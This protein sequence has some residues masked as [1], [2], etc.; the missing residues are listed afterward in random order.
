MKKVLQ[1]TDK[2]WLQ[3][4]MESRHISDKTMMNIGVPKRYLSIEDRN[5]VENA[6]ENYALVSQRGSRTKAKEL[7]TDHI[8]EALS[9]CIPGTKILAITFDELTA[10]LSPYRSKEEK[11]TMLYR[12]LLVCDM[13]FIYDFAMFHIKDWELK[14][15]GNYLQNRYNND[16]HFSLASENID[17]STIEKNIGSVI[18]EVVKS[19]CVCR[20]FQ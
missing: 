6:F 20:K 10:A 3:S 9:T 5:P 4:I 17:P 2:A 13:L 11:Y 18:W 15:I 12:Q 16:Q 14:F 19:H 7:L 8:F 1:I